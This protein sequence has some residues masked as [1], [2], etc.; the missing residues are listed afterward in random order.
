MKIRLEIDSNADEDEIVIHCR[1]LSPEIAELEKLIRNTTKKIDLHFYRD[2]TEYFIQLSEILFFEAGENNVTAHTAD[3]MYTV[4]N[5]L[6][7]LEE[8]LPDNFVRVSKSTI[9][10]CDKVFSVE[11]HISSFSTLQFSKTHKQVFVSRN[12]LKNLQQR[13]DKRRNNHEN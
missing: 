8:M 1:E 11:K 2:N 12:Y 5:K 7:M 13:L 10:N 3:N 9:L 4:K 6:Y